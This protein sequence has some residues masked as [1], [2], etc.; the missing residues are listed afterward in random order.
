[1]RGNLPPYMAHMYKIFAKLLLDQDKTCCMRKPRGYVNYPHA[2]ASDRREAA[3]ARGLGDLFLAG[4]PPLDFENLISSDGP[5]GA[6]LC[7]TGQKWPKNFSSETI[8]YMR[9]NHFVD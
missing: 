7:V 6:P 4:D 5:A 9:Q 3:I 8:A 2:S 1:M